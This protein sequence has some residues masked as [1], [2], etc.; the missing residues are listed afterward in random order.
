MTKIGVPVTKSKTKQ[1]KTKMWLQCKY[2]IHKHVLLAYNY[3]SF[4]FHKITISQ[5]HL[6]R[7]LVPVLCY[8]C[9]VA[10]KDKPLESAFCLLHFTSAGGSNFILF[11]IIFG[12]SY[13]ILFSKEN[14]RSVNG[15]YA[16]STDGH[17]KLKYLE[18]EG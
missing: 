13:F 15:K 3:K 7:A 1:K 14:T 18:W 8:S 2:T 12:E 11:S 17:R 16:M 10:Q 6:C 4:Y 9:R 5:L